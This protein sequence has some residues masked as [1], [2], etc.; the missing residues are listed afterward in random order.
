MPTKSGRHKLP[1]KT[2][3]PFW[4]QRQTNVGAAVVLGRVIHP[5]VRI[6]FKHVRRTRAVNANITPSK[7][8]RTQF[9]KEPSAFVPQTVSQFL[10]LNGERRKSFVV[11]PLQIRVLEISLWEIDTGR[12]CTSWA[13]WDRPGSLPPAPCIQSRRCTPQ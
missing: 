12:A 6:D 10:V 5:T 11:D 2:F 1:R 7:A 8:G 4:I 13:G 9:N 3:M